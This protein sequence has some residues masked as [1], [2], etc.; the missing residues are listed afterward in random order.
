[1]S[2]RSTAGSSGPVRCATR[3]SGIGAATTPDRTVTVACPALL[4]RHKG[5]RFAGSRSIAPPTPT[6]AAGG[7]V[8]LLRRGGEPAARRPRPPDRLALPRHGRHTKE[9]TRGMNDRILKAVRGEP[10]D[11]TPIWFM[12]QAGR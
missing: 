4:C 12:R 6:A 9:H 8:D 3:A 10:V 11:A 5:P 2:V 7:T 1:A